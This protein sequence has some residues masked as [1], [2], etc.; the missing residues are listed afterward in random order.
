MSKKSKQFITLEY[1]GATADGAIE[2]VLSFHPPLDR[3][4]ADNLFGF[5]GEI[6]MDTSILYEDGTRIS[7]VTAKVEP[8]GDATESF[9]T[10]ALKIAYEMGAFLG[11]DGGVIT[12]ENESSS[13]IGH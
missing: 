10:Q 9:E 1:V 2:P 8:S 11:K 4:T 7:L 13:D 5:L 6:G 12:V 3:A